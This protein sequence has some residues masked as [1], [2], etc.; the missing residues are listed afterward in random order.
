MTTDIPSGPE[1]FALAL[2]SLRYGFRL[3]PVGSGLPQKFLDGSCVHVGGD[4]GGAEIA[5]S[6][7]ELDVLGIGTAVPAAR[8]GNLDF[9]TS[10]T[11]GEPTL[12]K[13]ARPWY[14]YRGVA[15]NETYCAGM[16]FGPHVMANPSY[17]LGTL[18]PALHALQAGSA[19]VVQRTRGAE[20]FLDL[21]DRFGADSAFL[22]PDRLLELVEGARWSR[23]HLKIV[24]HGGAACPVPVKRDAIALMGPV[25]HE[26]YGTSECV[27]SEI[28]SLEWERRPGSVGRPLSGV[29]VTAV[30]EDGRPTP[31]GVP[32][33]IFVRPRRVDRTAV[34]GRLGIATGDLGYI[35][36]GYV[37]LLGRA[38]AT[39]STA[40]ALLEHRI[41]A[42]KGVADV[43]V[44]SRNGS[45]EC[46][47]ET[48][49]EAPEDLAD[50]ITAAIEASDAVRIP[51]TTA[52]RGSFGRT[53]SGK[54][55]RRR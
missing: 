31:P 6:L 46:L 27:I 40:H 21:V 16:N 15:V 39:G 5:V 8:A 45:D 29:L 43:A 24:F 3:L 47:V 14:G 34:G 25:L 30:S 38:G 42:V 53:P 7:D 19:V 10:G 2:A 12:V 32:G 33:E 48:M 17:H 26:F 44:A 51:I 18:G 28:G 22:S 9:A 13:R 50:R 54:L 37:H 36:D 23:H 1:F 52:P 20:A 41:R 55:R 35:E 11:T 49:P 4:V